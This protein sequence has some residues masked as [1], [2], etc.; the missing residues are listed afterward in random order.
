MWLSMCY[1]VIGKADLAIGVFDRL[2]TTHSTSAALY[3]QRGTIFLFFKKEAEALVDFE[4]A[5]QLESKSCLPYLVLA[6]REFNA[7]KYWEAKTL[8][9]KASEKNGTLESRSLAYQIIAMS[10][11][12]LNQKID[13]VLENLTLAE[14]WHPGNPTI[15]ENR[16]IALARAEKKDPL[17]RWKM[18]MPDPLDFAVPHSEQLDDHFHRQMEQMPSV[19]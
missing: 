6:Q 14:K 9:Q 18:E 17:E 13:W 15:A 11:S 12:M 2:L 19:A 3:T 16:A 7:G 1:A 8:G 5:I 10:L 4:K